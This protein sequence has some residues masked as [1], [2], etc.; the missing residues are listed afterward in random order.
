MVI[1]SDGNIRS[2]V[3]KCHEFG[4]GKKWKKNYGGKQKRLARRLVRGT[5]I[6]FEGVLGN[7]EKSRTLQSCIVRG[8]KRFWGEGG[9]SSV[10]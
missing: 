5:L 9:V 3:R 10:F 8:G 2:A 1:G 7:F 6:I 4:K